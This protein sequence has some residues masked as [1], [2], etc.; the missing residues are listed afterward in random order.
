MK[1]TQP[2]TLAVRQD[3]GT[4]VVH[5]T[6]TVAQDLINN[7]YQHALL[8]RKDQYHPQGFSRQ[9]TPVAFI[10]QQFKVHTLKH[11]KEFLLKY[12]V[13][14]YLYQELR[15]QKIVIVGNPRLLD[16]VVE[17]GKPAEYLFA[18]TQAPNMHIHDWKYLPF[19]SPVRRKYKDIDKQATNFI[20]EETTQ[21]KATTDPA[22]V[23][24]DWVHFRVTLVNQ[25]GEHFGTEFNESLWIQIGSDETSL[26][27]QELF[28]GK[29]AGDSFVTDEQC[30][31]EYFSSLLDTSYRFLM[32]VLA[33]LPF[34]YVDLGAMTT[35]FKLKSERKLHQKLVEVYSMRNDI[36]LRRSMAD[37]ALRL[38]LNTFP[39][40]APEHAVTAQMELIMRIVQENPDYAVYKQQRNFMQ[41]IHALAVKQVQEDI[42]MQHLAYSEN[43]TV[44]DD[45]VAQYLNL[46][47]RARTKE[48]IYFVHPSLRANEQELPISHESLK[49]FC[50]KEKTLNHLLY[51]LTKA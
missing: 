49:Q 45:D 35:H 1:Q 42:L 34:R 19:K 27:F 25:Q 46:T 16:V 13:V 29:Q 44:T 28:M 14:S 33:V 9:T 23:V 39:V 22:I 2:M 48:F 5:A 18:I 47:K 36:S 51:H 11:L 30:I 20:H 3:S 43:I 12:Y 17:Q 4:A 10:D 15:R 50:L 26:P 31:Q 6:V 8:Y 21:Q 40:Q 7:L 41:T 37:E 24:G 38:L 32:T